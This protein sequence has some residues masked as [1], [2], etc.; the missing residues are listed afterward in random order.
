MYDLEKKYFAMYQP[1]LEKRKAVI[2]GQEEPTMEG[3]VYQ[4]EEEDEEVSE[5]FKQ[6]AIDLKKSLPKY[7]ENVA[8]IPDF[9]LTVFK[10]T[11][12][13]SDMIQCH[14]E[15]ILKHLQDINIIHEPTE[16][17]Y[18]LVFE[19][20]TYGYFKDATLTK[21]YFL[22]SEID[23]EKPFNFDG[24]EICKWNPGKNVTVKMIKKKQ[25]H[26]ILRLGIS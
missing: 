16:M 6:M 2:N 23:K 24:L 11:E 26:P 9:W 19:F 7:D 14:H 1:I 22:R 12:V 18:T 20:S 13:L 5:N 8:G 3:C 4:S 15:P 17:A 10:S 25:K 21:K